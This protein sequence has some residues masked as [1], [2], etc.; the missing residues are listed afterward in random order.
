L[1]VLEAPYC[2]GRFS[3]KLKYLFIP[4]WIDGQVDIAAERA[5]L[6]RSRNKSLQSDLS[7]IRRHNLHCE[8]TQSLSQFDDFY[9]N[10]YLPYITRAHG[11]RS[12]VMTYGYVRTEFQK[13]RAFTELLLIK[14]DQEFIAG[15]LIHYSKRRARLLTL[16]VKDGNPDYIDRGAVGAAYHFAIQR[17]A[18]KGHTKID[19]GGSRPFLKDGVLRYKRKWH[20]RVS[21]RKGPAFLVKVL[22]QTP[23]LRGFFANNPFAY[24]DAAGLQG[25]VFVDGDKPLGKQDF[26]DIDKNLY[27]EGL[28]KLVIYRFGGAADAAAVPVPAEF[29]DKMTVAPAETILATM[30]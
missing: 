24:K 8:A 21:S 14:Q 10:M 28:S 6:F 27:V 11:D 29:A 30:R 20:Q 9:H 18:D 16:G 22:C 7:R 3:A 23:G 4:S 25:A 2:S 1:L 17:L 13:R 5:S 15:V 12:K 26:T 19:L